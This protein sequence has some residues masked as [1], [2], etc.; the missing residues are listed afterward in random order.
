ML[1]EFGSEITSFALGVGFTKLAQFARDARARHAS[2]W[3][4]AIH[5]EDDLEII[6]ANTPPWVS[7]STF[8]PGVDN[9]DAFQ[10]PT[11]GCPIV[12]VRGF[13]LQVVRE[14]VGVSH[15]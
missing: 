11:G 1:D 5:V 7:A 3:P 9:L 6:F 2:S 14:S 15:G 8:I 13:G 4:V 12:C 10:P